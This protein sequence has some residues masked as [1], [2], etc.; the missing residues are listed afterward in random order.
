MA[1]VKIGDV[2]SWW[3]GESGVVVAMT[4]QWCIFVSDRVEFAIPWDEVYICAEPPDEAVGAITEM[5]LP[6]GK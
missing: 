2:V 4:P 6:G 3:G 5:E 1:K